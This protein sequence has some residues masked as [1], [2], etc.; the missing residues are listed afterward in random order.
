MSSLLAGALRHTVG[1]LLL[2][3]LGLRLRLGLW[4]PQEGLYQ[5]AQVADLSSVATLRVS[6]GPWRSKVRCL[7]PLPSRT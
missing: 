5:Q 6:G 7:K 1:P 4:G 3:R 2:L